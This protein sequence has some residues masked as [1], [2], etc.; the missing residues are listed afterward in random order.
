MGRGGAVVASDDPTGERR[1]VVVTEGE[2]GVPGG[3]RGPAQR[4][5]IAAVVYPAFAAVP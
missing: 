3:V 4:V 5:E 1:A 2:V